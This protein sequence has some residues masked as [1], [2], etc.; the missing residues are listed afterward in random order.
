MN[1][2]VNARDMISFL[3]AYSDSTYSQG[4]SNPALLN[5]WGFSYGVSYFPYAS[6]ILT[7]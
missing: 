1:S 3:N 4:V 6:L 7:R 2:G 5:Y